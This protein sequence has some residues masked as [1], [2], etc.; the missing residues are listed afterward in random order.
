MSDGLVWFLARM[1]DYV[2]HEQPEA[3]VYGVAR[4]LGG[5]RSGLDGDV[6]RALASVQYEA[7]L[8]LEAAL[9]SASDDERD[10][11]L[12]VAWMGREDA[13][14]HVAEL[15]AA[16]NGAGGSASDRGDDAGAR[17]SRRALPRHGLRRA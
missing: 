9:A 2:P 5:D 8:T 14:D 10:R 4:A 16:Q 11:L 6:A 3:V 7:A 13:A 17:R 1:C 15:A 12:A